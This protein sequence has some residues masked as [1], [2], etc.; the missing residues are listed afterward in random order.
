MEYPR[1]GFAAVWTGRQL[2][3]WG[4]SN[5]TGKIYTD[6]AAYTPAQ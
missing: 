6:G 1:S 4:G 3:V 5:D 2:I